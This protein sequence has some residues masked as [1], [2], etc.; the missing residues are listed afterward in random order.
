MNIM[1]ENSEEKNDRKQETKERKNICKAKGE[2][3]LP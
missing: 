3:K 1:Q 2:K